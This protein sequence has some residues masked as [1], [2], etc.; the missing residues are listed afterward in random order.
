MSNDI[1]LAI[2]NWP[3]SAGQWSDEVV[4]RGWWNLF[5]ER[6][7]DDDKAAEP[8]PDELAMPKAA[9][10]AGSDS[11]GIVADP[12]EAREVRVKGDEFQPKT[13]GEGG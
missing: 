13:L 5:P 6:K 11:S 10:Q 4:A 8:E 7:Q 3:D 12:C 2:R 1:H 9:G